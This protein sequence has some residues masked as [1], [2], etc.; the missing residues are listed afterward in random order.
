VTAESPAA[1]PPEA[2][3]PLRAD[4]ARNRRQVLQAAREQLEGGDTALPMNRIAHLAGVG[5]GTVY[6]HFPTRQS[7]L[8]ALAQRSFEILV[9]EAQ[10]AVDAADPA[11]GLQQMLRCTLQCQLDDVALATILAAP[12]FECPETLALG[13]ELGRSVTT[14]LDRSRTCGLI[15]PDIDADDLRRLVSGVHHALRA[16]PFGPALFDRYLQVLVR[17]LRA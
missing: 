12:T 15:R 5:V 14:I 2:T 16:G 3:S 7:L 6:R 11:A 8:E 17:G 1:A 4:A 13:V 10:A 9:G